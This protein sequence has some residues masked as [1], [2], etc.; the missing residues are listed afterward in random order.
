MRQ[1]AK[2]AVQLE[3]NTTTKRVSVAAVDTVSTNQKKVPSLV[4]CVVLEKPRE[5]QKLSR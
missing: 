1:I 3:R 5:Q 2:N 4:K